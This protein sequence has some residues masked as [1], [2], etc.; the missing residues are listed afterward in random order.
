MRHSITMTVRKI[1]VDTVE[2]IIPLWS[3]TV[4][5]FVARHKFSPDVK[6]G[7]EFRGLVNMHAEFSTDLNVVVQGQIS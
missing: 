7:D 4:Y 6:V 3:T 2:V 1:H 5:P